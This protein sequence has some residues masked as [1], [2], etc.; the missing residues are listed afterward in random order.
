M[1]EYHIKLTI[2]TSIEKIV[3][4][5]SL[6]LAEDKVWEDLINT[7]PRH[8]HYILINGSKTYE[9]LNKEDFKNDN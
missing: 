9:L 8:G 5:D 3:D 2:R 6:E 4:A 1:A 7:D